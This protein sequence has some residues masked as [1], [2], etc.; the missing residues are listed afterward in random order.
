MRKIVIIIVILILFGGVVSL[1]VVNLSGLINRNKEYLLAQAE[2]TLGREVTVGEIGVT[3]WGGIGVRLR[4]FTLADDPAFSQEDF[5]RAADL[6]VNVE[7]L[8][9]FWKELR[10]KRLILHQP[11]ITIIRNQQGRFNFASLG[12]GTSKEQPPTQEQKDIRELPSSSTAKPFPL[13]AAFMNLA[14]GTVRYVD[15]QDRTDLQVNRVDLTVEDLSFDRPF[16]LVLNSAVLA[17]QQNFGMQSRI[18]PLGAAHDLKNLPVEGVL[19]IDGLD[20]D[21]LQEALPQLAKQLPQGLGLSGSLQATLNMEG[22]MGALTFSNVE[23]ETSIFGATKPNVKVAGRVGPVGGDMKELPLKGDIALGPVVLA[24]VVRFAP[25]AVALPPDFSADGPLSLKTHVDG[26]LQN[27]ALTGTVEVSEGAFRFGEQFKKPQGVP[28]VLSTHAQMTSAMIALQKVTLRLH[29]VELTGS[30]KINLGN[31]LSLD[32]KIDTPPTTLAGWQELLPLVQNYD[33]GGTAEAHVRLQ[34]AVTKEQIPRIA[35]SVTLNQVTAKVPQVPTPVTDLNATVA[36]TGQGAEVKDA[37][38]QIGNSRVRFDGNVE[39]FTPFALVYRL[40]LPELHWADLQAG[41]ASGADASVLQEVKS[42][43]RVRRDAGSLAYQG[44]VSSAQGML[45][46]VPYKNFQ[47][48]LFLETQSVNIENA[49]LQAFGGS[50]QGKGRYVFQET[51]PEFSL[52]SQVRGI[53]LTELFRSALT[54]ASQNI[55]G[56]ANLD[57]TVSGKGQGWEE[58]KTSL[59]GEGHAEVLQGALLN[60]N[61]AEGVLSG[62][63]G[64]PGLSLLVSP[65]VRDHYPEIFATQNTPF[66]ELHSIFTINNGKMNIDD[67][68]ISAIDYTMQG[69]GWVDFDQRL[70]LRAQLILSQKLSADIADDVKAA[71]YIVNEQERVELPFALVGVLPKVSSQ[72]D[73]AYVGNLLQRAALRRGAEELEKRVLKKLLPSSRQP[74]PT[75]DDGDAEPST[76]EKPRQKDPAEQLLRKG[77]DKLFGR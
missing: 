3:L 44:S 36:F 64:L 26:T 49:S 51:F 21:A 24:Q 34:G 39:T 73:L 4:N 52:T 6:Q 29:T 40:S 61:I 76:A 2:Q 77:L 46:Q 62:V 58:M 5:L 69:R 11:A 38:L 63:T 59:Q 37:S 72:P 66:D 75:E 17:E 31:S 19:E 57:F 56:Q 55:E 65:R 50:V 10:V 16:E 1:A 9:L 12:S 18:G 54:T 27:L 33:L 28:F 23:L 68:R 45:S 71:K 20:V 25:V 14:D 67:L 22:P 42:E 32:L 60:V 13:I 30:G 53:N 43:G 35:G 15:R 74:S 8:P 47:T 7:F 70:D 41:A 48:D